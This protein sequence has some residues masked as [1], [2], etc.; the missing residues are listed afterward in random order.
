[1]KKSQIQ[2]SLVFYILVGAV[3]LMILIF[4]FMSLQKSRQRAKEIEQKKLE[5]EIDASVKEIEYGSVERRQLQVPPGTKEICFIDITK[6]M[7]VLSSPILKAE[8]YKRRRNVMQSGERKNIFFLIQDDPFLTS[9]YQPGICFD[10]YPY[11]VCLEPRASILN[12]Y[13][14]GKGSCALIVMEYKI[15]ETIP[16][17]QDTSNKVL[18]DISFGSIYAKLTIPKDT[19]LTPAP[20]EICIEAVSRIDAQGL[21]SEVYNITPA[22]ITTDKDVTI[23]M[24]YEDYLLPPNADAGYIKLMKSSSPWDVL[25]NL[26]VDTENSRVSGIANVLSYFA[27]FGPQP[28]TAVIKVNGAIPTTEEVIVAKDTPVNFDGSASTDPDGAGD[29]ISYS[30]DFGDGAGTGATVTHTYTEM[31]SYNTTLTVTDITGYYDLKKI[32]VNV[33]NDVN[34]KNSNKINNIIIITSNPDWRKI[35]SL[36]PLAM[37]KDINIQGNHIIPY[38]VYHKNGFPASNAFKIADL[39]TRYTKDYIVPTVV[40]FGA[41]IQ[42]SGVQPADDYFSYW[43]SYED[44][45]VV[46]YDNEPAALMASLFAAFINAP[47]IFIDSTHLPDAY[48]MEGKTAYVIDYVS[49]DET[50]RTNYL[51]LAAEITQ[52]NMADL[53]NPTKN[54]Y[55]SLYSNI[56]LTSG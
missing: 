2:S 16:Y 32:T 5:Q 11:F 33:V 9:I 34:K 22:H 12:L 49:K 26:V 19:V 53:Q 37:W 20:N 25:A 39:K 7:D 4:A 36:V 23:D 43:S 29:I 3:I 45:V 38:L 1:M 47:I 31:G 52:Y 21:I 24:K 41:E 44:I 14:E 46:G 55:Q 54:P 51:S 56:V 15:C 48:V 27:V 50:T 10:H 13:L 30:W 6:R 35:L 17:Y 42:L 18:N 8:K 28:P 40:H